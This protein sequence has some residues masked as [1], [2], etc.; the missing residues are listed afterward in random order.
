MSTEAKPIIEDV[1]HKLRKKIVRDIILE[2]PDPPVPFP[3][4]VALPESPTWPLLMAPFY[5]GFQAM[6]DPK[7]GM[8]H[9]NDFPPTWNYYSPN[10]EHVLMG[11]TYH[12]NAPAPEYILKYMLNVFADT[13]F[14][15]DPSK[16]SVN[17]TGQTD[18]NAS[19]RSYNVVNLGEQPPEVT[20]PQIYQVNSPET[21]NKYLKAYH[22]K[23]IL[24]AIC[25]P[26]DSDCS[27]DQYIVISPI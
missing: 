7:T 20:V 14:V 16:F 9:W 10:T 27:D 17:D 18:K 26:L 12:P 1:K 21:L 22:D 24:G 5:G 2:W 11:E 3:K 19:P 4:R 23:G 6:F 15:L 13:D 8:F 25:R